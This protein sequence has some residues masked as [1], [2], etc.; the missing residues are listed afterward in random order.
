MEDWEDEPIPDLMKK[1]TLKS[2]WDDE[3]VED[4]DVKDSWEDEDEPAPAPKAEPPPPEK[5][6]KKTAVK[7]ADKK[8]KA[9]EAAKEAP[10]DPIAEKLR[11][12]R[13]VEEADYKSTAELFAKKGDEKTLDNFIPKT[14]NDFLE[15]AELVAN[16]LR[17][18]EKSYHYIGLLKAVMRLSLTSLKGAD[19]KE[20]ASSVT[21]IANEKIKAEKEANAGKKKTGGKKKQL[22]VGKQEDDVIADTFDDYDDYDFM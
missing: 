4:N 21:A 7:S 2:K 3:D 5:A 15:Y 14:E 18:F 11:Q 19:A 22:H 12:Q 16:K 1:E 9:V 20:V 13:L 10:L 8:G 17:P 6:S